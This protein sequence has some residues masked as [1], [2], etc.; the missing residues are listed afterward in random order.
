VLI[1]S[2]SHY[3]RYRAA[4][5]RLTDEIGSSTVIDALSSRLL[6]AVGLTADLP[7][8]GTA[9]A[10]RVLFCRATIAHPALQKHAFRLD[11]LGTEL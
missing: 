11:E 9:S 4:L 1:V 3:C 5:R 6:A 2:Y 10:V 8:P 7:P